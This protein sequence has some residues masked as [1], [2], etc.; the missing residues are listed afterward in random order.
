MGKEEKEQKLEK[1]DQEVT[2]WLATCRLGHVREALHYLGVELL[3]NLAFYVKDEDAGQ[4]ALRSTVE[5]RRF[6]RA[7]RDV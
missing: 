4:L 7:L 2:V 3:E 6:R 1:K 5:V